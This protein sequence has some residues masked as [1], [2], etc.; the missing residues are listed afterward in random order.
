MPRK[1]FLWGL[2]HRP[3]QVGVPPASILD[4]ALVALTAGMSAVFTPSWMVFCGLGVIHGFWTAFVVFLAK[5][6]LQSHDFTNVMPRA[7]SQWT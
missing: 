4:C 1:Q 5:G 7:Q 2:P 3:A 6:G